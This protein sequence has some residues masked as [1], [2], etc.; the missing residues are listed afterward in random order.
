MCSYFWSLD[1]LNFRVRP[2]NVSVLVTSTAECYM[3]WHFKPIIYCAQPA[4]NDLCHRTSYEA[5]NVSKMSHCLTA[6]LAAILQMAQQHTK[7]G[8]L[9]KWAVKKISLNKFAFTK[10]KKKIELPVFAYQHVLIKDYDKP[11]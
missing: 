11:C 9:E 6:S 8:F 4:F 7:L 1:K 3:S 2:S 10:K 5:F